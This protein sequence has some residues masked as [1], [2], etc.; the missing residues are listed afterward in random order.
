MADLT[1]IY[2]I[3]GADESGAELRCA[4]HPKWYADVESID[5][6]TAVGHAIDHFRDEHRVHVT[7]CACRDRVTDGRCV[8]H[9]GIVVTGSSSPAVDRG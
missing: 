2:V 5:L 3:A 1:T 9:P 7:G 8:P 4:W 6:P